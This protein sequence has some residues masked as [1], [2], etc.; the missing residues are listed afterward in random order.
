[1][2]KY[3]ITGATGYIG[4]ML[5]KHLL[6]LDNNVEI[7]ALVRNEEKA[8]RILPTDVKII[9]A[10]I[11]NVAA[12][13]NI[14]GEFDYIIHTAAVT[15]SSYMVTH[16]V[17]TADSIIL[18][19]KNILELARRANIKSMVYLSSMEV[20]GQVNL[21]KNRRAAESDLGFVDIYNPR[22][23]YPLGKRMAEHYCYAYFK[24]YNVP[25]KIARLAQT[26][27]AGVSKDDNR[28]FAQFAKS[29]VN[30]NDIILH[31][32][33]MSVGN[34]CAV[35]DALAA[36][37]LLLHNG[38]SGEVYNVANENLTMRIR[39]MA[40]LVAG[41][42]ALGKISVSYEIDADNGHG[43]APSTELRLSAAKLMLLGWKPTKS[44]VDMYKD[45]LQSW[46]NN[47]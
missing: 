10:D 43:Y 32:D 44:M 6:S 2:E 16:P 13:S 15:A 1:M 4:S 14:K 26:F 12:M 5:V 29:T 21:P 47:P 27:G 38:K 45:L 25:V 20:F 42:A 24:E 7:T 11:T 46:Q 35:D 8:K 22:S 28:V 39:D 30:G 9:C 41:E 3:L 31:T 19:T 36:I 34:Y 40:E 37:C 23:C 17:E 18:G 33:G